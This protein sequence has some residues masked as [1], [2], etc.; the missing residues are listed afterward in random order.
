[1]PLPR[2]LRTTSFRLTLLY[3]V[4]F[5]GSVLLLFG[6]MY[7]YGTGYIANQ[8]DQTVANEIAEIETNEG[9]GLPSMQ[10]A[11]AKYAAQASPGVFYLLQDARAHALAGNIPALDPVTG[12]QEWPSREDGGNFPRGL[13]SVRG[14]GVRTVDGAYLLVG[15]D[16]NELTEM[17]EMITYAFGWGLLGTILLALGGGTLMSVG[18]L[19]HVEHIANTSRDIVAGDLSRRLPVRGT[20]DEFDL[21]ATSF[22][23]TLDRIE[24][25]MLGLRQVS[26]DIAHDLRTPLSRL[27]QRL[28][29]ARRRA[30]TIE[31][32]H[33]VLDDSIANVDG[34]LD[35][36]AGLLRIAQ[37]EAHAQATAFAPLD[38]TQLLLDMVETYQS[39]AEE[40][41]QT[42]NGDIAPGLTMVGDRELL[43][44]LFSNLIENAIRHAPG[45]AK[46]GVD[47]R[48]VARGLEI[49]ITDN[50]PGIPES[51]REKVFQRF[52]RLEQSRTTDGTGLGLS[53][54]AAIASL[55]RA[56]IELGDNH[57][58][59]RVLVKVPPPDGSV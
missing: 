18:L 44:Q 33:A 55:H 9:G 42:L 2:V 23:A 54:A 25:L 48:H 41:G 8:I 21:L 17:R 22:N 27:R 47:A 37:I 50:G 28:E 40:K 46:I 4:L 52:F 38:L 45:G 57:P 30:H 7:W 35:T 14:R 5:F 24:S 29:L 43:P 1:M 26:S 32:L 49:A 39:V 56:R 3:A 53:L 31:E 16:S 36:F 59:L 11:V 51:M 20:H 10:A 58:G 15:L 6:A 12:I 13:H 19:R 34:I